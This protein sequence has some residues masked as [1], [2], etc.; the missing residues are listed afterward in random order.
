MN[1]THV[2]NVLHFQNSPVDL[3]D[4]S[5]TCGD[6]SVFLP[7]SPTTKAFSSTTV[8]PTSPDPLQQTTGA[9]AHLGM[10]GPEVP[11]AP[12]RLVAHPPFHVFNL[13]NVL[14]LNFLLQAT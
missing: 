14:Q 10:A 5:L 4:T 13:G 9:F 11:S 3:P 8:L 1:S 2:S 12:G 6:D 7:S